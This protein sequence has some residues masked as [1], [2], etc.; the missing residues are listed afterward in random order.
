MPMQ[1]NLTTWDALKSLYKP[2][3]TIGIVLFSAKDQMHK[4]N[5]P[6]RQR[7]VQASEAWTPAFQKWLRTQNAKGYNVSIAANPLTPG[8]K[9][10]TKETV[11]EIRYL[12]LDLDTKN[13]TTGKQRLDSMLADANCPAPRAILNTSPDNYQVLWEVKG[14]TKEGAEETL[15]SLAIHYGGDLAIGGDVSRALRAPGL[16]NKKYA[17]HDPIQPSPSSNEERERDRLHG[18]TITG[19]IHSDLVHMPEHFAYLP[20]RDLATPKSE[21]INR[22]LELELPATNTATPNGFD[23]PG[24][25]AQARSGRGSSATDQSDSG[26]DWGHANYIFATQLRAG[27]SLT[28]ISSEVRGYLET[29]AGA[30][31]R[32]DGARYAETTLKKLLPQWEAKQAA[33]SPPPETAIASPARQITDAPTAPSF[34]VPGNFGADP[35][36]FQRTDDERNKD[37]T[38][39]VQSLRDGQTPGQIRE[40]MLDWHFKDISGASDYI[41]SALKVALAAIESD[42]LI[43]TAVEYVRVHGRS[44]EQDL[45]LFRT[46]ISQHPQGDGTLSNVVASLQ[47]AEDFLPPA[48]SALLPTED[49]SAYVTAFQIAG[50][51][52]NHG[53]TPKS[54]ETALSQHYY[55]ALT[56]GSVSPDIANIVHHALLQRSQGPANFAQELPR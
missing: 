46:L 31:G 54:V 19:H 40:N 28:D 35:I 30:R 20:A 33:Y 10:R 25:V 11:R 48:P 41:H 8:S 55:P 3:D 56:H 16:R 51:A 24:R 38:Y 52:L 49:H 26:R 6:A 29:S 36:G 42:S 17:E 50:L 18:P 7:I 14:F 37:A 15:R 34:P 23:G 21:V 27:K 47:K 1:T 45:G 12:Y 43:T 44:H 9:T 2:D 13:G 4:P 22:G 32:T 39:I 53:D 5:P